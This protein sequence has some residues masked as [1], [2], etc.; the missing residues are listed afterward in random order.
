MT[1]E[2]F[3]RRSYLPAQDPTDPSLGTLSALN[4]TTV[5]YKRVI[6]SDADLLLP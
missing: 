2:Q 6:A 5:L 1:R 3:R 4:T